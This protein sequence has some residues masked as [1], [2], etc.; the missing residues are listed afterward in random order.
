MC[1]VV[2]DPL[3]ALWS[4]SWRVAWVSFSRHNIL[5]YKTA[6]VATELSPSANQTQ[7]LSQTCEAT[8]VLGT[9]IDCISWIM[10]LTLKSPWG[11][12]LVPHNKTTVHAQ[13]LS[14]TVNLRYTLWPQTETRGLM[15]LCTILSVN[16]IIWHISTLTPSQWENV[17]SSSTM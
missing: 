2:G 1:L 13:W 17:Q 6:K 12:R 3:N 4:N 14:S 11:C 9:H 10:L 7:E 8:I 15:S 5:G 16:D